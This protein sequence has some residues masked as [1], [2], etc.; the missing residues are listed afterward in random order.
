MGIASGGGVD[1]CKPDEDNKAEAELILKR[2][3]YFLQGTW[4]VRVGEKSAEGDVL[5]AEAEMKGW[6]AAA[7]QV[8]VSLDGQ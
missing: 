4:C 5:A 2:L 6:F 8:G 7:E 3:S 1:R